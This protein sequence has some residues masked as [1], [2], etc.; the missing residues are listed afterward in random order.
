MKRGYFISFEGMDGSGK[1]TQIRKLKEYFE[2]KD[3]QVILTREPGGTDI[4]EKIRQLI[5]DPENIRMTALTE[6]MLYAA[7]RAQHVSEVIRPAVDSG[8]VVICDRFV[9]SSIAYQGCGRGLGECV[10]V[11][12]DY[13][14]DGYMPDLTFLLDIVPG[15]STERIGNREKDR[16]ELEKQEFHDAVYNGYCELADAFPERI[17]KIDA[18]GSI[19]EIQKKITDHIEKLIGEENSF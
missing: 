5:L 14:V 12:N 11:I 2:D 19:D 13:A 18:S 17:A 8:K 16:I 7:S 6:A 15:A 10:D 4:G 1:S 9:D 3:Y